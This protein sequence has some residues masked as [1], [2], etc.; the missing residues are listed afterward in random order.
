MGGQIL[1]SHRIEYQKTVIV[2]NVSQVP[3]PLFGGPANKTIPALDLQRPALPSNRSYY[4]IPS[5]DQISQLSAAIALKA[6]I[7]VSVDK[8]LPHLRFSFMLLH[9]TYFHRL[10]IRENTRY[11]PLL[12]SRRADSQNI[13]PMIPFSLSLVGLCWQGAFHPSRSG[14]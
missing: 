7:V 9:T 12:N 8:L 10:N 13:A 1:H 4:S 2:E 14:G 6:K 11:S 5:K 3:P